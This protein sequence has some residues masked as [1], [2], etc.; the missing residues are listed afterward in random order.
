MIQEARTENPNIGFLDPQVVI[1]TMVEFQPEEVEDY[2][3]E[4]MLLLCTKR[5]ILLPYNYGFHWMLVCLE[6]QHL[7]A[8]YFDSR[9]YPPE[10]YANL[11]TVLNEA[12]KKYVSK[13]G[14]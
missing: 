6:P 14:L 7:H 10:K 1:C 9:D 4:A 8:T 11:T 5:L 2:I 12:F 13:G 3:S